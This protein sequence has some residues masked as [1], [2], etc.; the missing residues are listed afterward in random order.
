MIHEKNRIPEEQAENQDA[1][2]IHCEG[3]D[4][5]ECHTCE[6]NNRKWSAKER[7]QYKDIF[8]LIQHLA[9]NPKFHKECRV[10]VSYQKEIPEGY[11][12]LT[13]DERILLTEILTHSPVYVEIW[14]EKLK[15]HLIASGE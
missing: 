11:R 1:G 9:F 3:C 7:E 15:A 5:L 10:L 2:P 8:L 13:Y 14:M 6:E 4:T 12:K